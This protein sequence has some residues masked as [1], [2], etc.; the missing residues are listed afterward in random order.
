MSTTRPRAYGGRSAGAPRP[1]S[2]RRWETLGLRVGLRGGRSIATRQYHQGALRVLRPHYLDGSGQVC[3]VWS[4]RAGPTWAATFTAS[5]S[6]WTGR[7]LLLTT[8]SA[9]KVYRTPGRAE[10]RRPIRLGPGAQLEYVPDQLIAYREAT[11]RQNTHVEM[12]PRRAW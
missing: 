7:R 11:Y 4:I 8:Q 5:T 10:Q 3:Y 2:N 1:P 6:R 12:R 9:T